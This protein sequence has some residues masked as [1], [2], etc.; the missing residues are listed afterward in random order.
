MVCEFD[1]VNCNLLY[2]VDSAWDLTALGCFLEPSHVLTDAALSLVTTWKHQGGSGL[3]VLLQLVIPARI[4]N[5]HPGKPAR[6]LKRSHSTL[7]RVGIFGIE[8]T[9]APGS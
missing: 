9:S 5:G 8:A 4:E 2:C 6:E 7:S 1:A 3:C